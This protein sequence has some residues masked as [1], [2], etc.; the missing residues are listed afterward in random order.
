[1]AQWKPEYA[2]EFANAHEKYPG[3]EQWS[4]TQFRNMDLY[5]NNV[6]RQIGHDHP[7]AT[8]QELGNLVMDALYSGHLT[9]ISPSTCR[10]K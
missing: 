2:A 5:N 9:W 4:E 7:G 6:G 10:K 3:W 8:R 1:M